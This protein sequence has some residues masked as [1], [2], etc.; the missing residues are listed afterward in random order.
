MGDFVDVEIGKFQHDRGVFHAVFVNQLGERTSEMLFQKSRTL[1]FGQRKL[2]GKI[3]QVHLVVDVVCDEGFYGADM[4][5][6]V[7]QMGSVDRF[8]RHERKK[9]GGTH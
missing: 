9:Q 8:L 2:V 1:L 4:L 3:A 7:D 5:G 6:A